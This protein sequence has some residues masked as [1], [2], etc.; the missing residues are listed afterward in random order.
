MLLNQILIFVKCE[1]EMTNNSLNFIKLVVAIKVYLGHAVTHLKISVPYIF[2]IYDLFVGVPIFFIISGFLIWGSIKDSYN[3]KEF[4]KR[5]LWR[6]YPELW[7][8]VCLSITTIILLK[9]YILNEPYTIPVFVLTQ[10]T[11]FQFYTPEVLR[12]F[13]CGVPNGSLWTIT[14]IVQSYVALFTIYKYYKNK[15]IEKY[16]CLFILLCITSICCTILE[17][18]VPSLI[19]KIVSVTFIP[20]LW[21]FLL[22]VILNEFYS[23]FCTIIVKHCWFFAFASVLIRKIGLDFDIMGY[24][25]VF[26]NVLMALAI[27]GFA[28]RY[29]HLNL[30]Y[31]FSY[32]IYLYHMVII[33]VF[34]ELGFL[35]E[36]KY[37]FVCLVITILVSIISYFTIGS[38][39]RINRKKVKV[40]S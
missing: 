16:L 34:V 29:N 26:T 27:I 1:N 12:N 25:G 10:A 13:G 3:Y 33:N 5:R 40:V 4:L 7:F 2:R 11:I 20:Y 35:Y 19:Y 15:K 30:S 22:G 17:K 14:I 23:R 32:G 37:L 24:Y 6:I 18:Y 31:D 8:A 36:Y 21:L 9:S 39:C 38:F 28:F